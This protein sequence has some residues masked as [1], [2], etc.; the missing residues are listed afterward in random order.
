M[1]QSKGIHAQL[2]AA[3][4]KALDLNRLGAM[5]RRVFYRELLHVETTGSQD[6][7]SQGA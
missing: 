2:P 6:P 7:V 3:P 5:P 1:M 4:R